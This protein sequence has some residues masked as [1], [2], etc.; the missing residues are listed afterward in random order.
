MIHPGC[1]ANRNMKSGHEKPGESVREHVRSDGLP[2]SAMT[3]KSN[4]SAK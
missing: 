2:D 1:Y 4:Q 3:F